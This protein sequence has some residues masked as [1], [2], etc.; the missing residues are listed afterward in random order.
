VLVSNGHPR[1][2][3]TIISLLYAAYAYG[4]A[5]KTSSSPGD[6]GSSSGSWWSN[7]FALCNRRTVTK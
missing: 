6:P 2:R 7:S 5:Y 4:N 1:P 3:F